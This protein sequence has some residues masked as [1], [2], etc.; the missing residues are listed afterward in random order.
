MIKA[1]EKIRT[2]VVDFARETIRIPSLTGEEGELARF[3]LRKL[4]EIGIEESFIDAAGNVVGILRGNG[5]G[6][7]IMLNGHLD[8][9]P[10]G[11]REN[12]QYEPFGAEIDEQG[13]IHG[14]GTADLKGGMAVQFYTMKLLK[15]LVDGGVSLPGDVIFSQVVFEEAA[16]MLGMEY[17]CKKTLPEKNLNFD[18]VYICEP[19]SLGVYLGHRGKVEIVVTTK[20]ITAH[21]STPWAGINALEKML[22][23]LDAIFKGMSSVMKSHPELGKSSITITN[24]ICRPGALSVMPDECEISIDRRY[25]P[26]ETLESILEE[27]KQLFREIK[28]KDPKFEATVQPRSFLEKSYTGYEKEVKKYHPVW[29]TDKENPFVQK[30]LVALKKVGQEPKTGYWRFG[31]DGSMSAGL[32]GIPT[33]GYS[34]MEEKYAH[35]PDEQVNIDKMMQSLEGYAS[36]VCELFDI[37]IS[38]LDK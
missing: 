23:V 9:V 19:T 24:L 6:P 11:N 14:R 32:M 38:K 20:G 33:M 1:V 18:V 17:L 25:V 21:S 34:G 27:F 12:W 7:N 31:T 28:K 37:D 36:I 13:N 29:T 30:T 22:P 5:K 3:L 2:E 10:P 8:V 4:K 35:T 16:E 26:G 15:D